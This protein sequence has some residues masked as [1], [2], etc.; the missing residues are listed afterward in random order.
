MEK[1]FQTAAAIPELMGQSIPEHS[2]E[3]KQLNRLTGLII[4]LCRSASPYGWGELKVM[5]LRIMTA[6]LA[7]ALLMDM[8]AVVEA[9]TYGCNTVPHGSTGHK[10]STVGGDIICAFGQLRSKLWTQENYYGHNPKNLA[11]YVYA[12][13][14]GNGDEASGDGYNYR[15]RGLIQITFHDNY[16]AFSREHKRF[17]DD[18]QVFVQD[19]DLV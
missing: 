10:F 7:C 6:V 12:K 17:P 1:W 15:G 2:E 14:Y 13:R 16:E 5:S 8:Q 3:L 9:S 4:E 11:S 19:P 18:Q